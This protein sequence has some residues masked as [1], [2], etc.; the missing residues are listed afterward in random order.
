M[1]TRLSSGVCCLFVGRGG[2][3]EVEDRVK[4][5]GWPG[6]DGWGLMCVFAGEG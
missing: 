3:G 6:W 2:H 5:L 1:V 4:V